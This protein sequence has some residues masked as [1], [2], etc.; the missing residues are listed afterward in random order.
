[1]VGIGELCFDVSR[2]M[3]LLGSGNRRNL[4]GENSRCILDTPFETESFGSVKVVVDDP[5][6]IG[7]KATTVLSIDAAWP[8]GRLAP[9]REK[10]LL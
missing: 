1:M 4:R 3:C 10:S 5:I 7:H 6:R 2:R 9:M 8:P